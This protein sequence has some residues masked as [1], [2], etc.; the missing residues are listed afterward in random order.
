MLKFDF[1]S[2]K[3]SNG[4]NVILFYFIIQ[5]LFIYSYTLQILAIYVDHFEYYKIESNLWSKY[6]GGNMFKKHLDSCIYA[7]RFYIHIGG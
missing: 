5:D 4:K 7:F 3:K 2:T 6:R 1:R